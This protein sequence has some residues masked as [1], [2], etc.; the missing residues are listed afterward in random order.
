MAKQSAA[1]AEPAAK[2]P[3]ADPQPAPSVEDRLAEKDLRIEELE[4]QNDS[5]A[6]S[7]AEKDAV[8]ADI[9]SR[10]GDAQK[11]I[12]EQSAAVEE[13]ASKL[14]DARELLPKPEPEPEPPSPPPVIDLTCIYRCVARRK[15]RSPSG[16]VSDGQEFEASGEQLEG[17]TH[18][19]HFEIVKD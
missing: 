12:A 6:R 18:G 9:T 19:D 1:A 4:A 10:L 17:Y 8:I 16:W 3:A 11:R 7:V 15:M 14:A 2:A 5:L 13:L